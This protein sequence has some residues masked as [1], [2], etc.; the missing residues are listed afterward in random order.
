MWMLSFVP[1]AL[2]HMVVIGIMFAGISLYAF[3]FITRVLPPLIPYT[4]MIRILGTILT[5]VGIYFFGSY[6]TE[7][8][9]RNKVAELEAARDMEV[10]RERL[11]EMTK[12]RDVVPIVDEVV[13]GSKGKNGELSEDLITANKKKR[14]ELINNYDKLKALFECLTKV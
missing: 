6:S 11:P 13:E 10:L 2:L 8:E 12:G 14:L 3:S 9:W 1:D 4:G 5:V 7:M